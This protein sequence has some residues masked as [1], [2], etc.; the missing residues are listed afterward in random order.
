MR[1]RQSVITLLVF[2]SF[3]F[4]VYGGNSTTT[5]EVSITDASTNDTQIEPLVYYDETL[6]NI[7]ENINYLTLDSN[8]I[9]DIEN[10][11]FDKFNKLEHLSLGNNE[12]KNLTDGV[13]TEKLGSTLKNLNLGGNSLNILQT[14]FK[15]MTNLKSLY[16]DKSYNVEKVFASNSTWKFPKSLS[17]LETLSLSGCNIASIPDNIF[18]NL[19]LDWTDK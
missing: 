12:T 3:I 1:F 6:P 17:N 15:Y 2:L 7:A 18:E 8:K 16:L 13:L 10:G 14:D 19:I 4:V 9:T 11:T 5:P